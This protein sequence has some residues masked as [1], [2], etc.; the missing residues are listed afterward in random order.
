MQL[1][2]F[3]GSPRGMGSN[4]KVIIE[5]FLKGFESLENNSHEL[6][7]LIRTQEQEIFK[8]TFQEAEAVLVVF[9][10]YTDSMPGI[11]KTFIETLEPLC[12][13]ENNPPIAF[14][15][16]SGFPEGVHLRSLEKYL[17]KLACRL[18]CRYIGTVVKGNSESLQHSPDEF[19]DSWVKNF[20][21][22]GEIFAKTGK[23]E[24]ELLV[25]MSKPEKFPGW[26]GGFF[27]LFARTPFLTGFWDSEM[28]KKRG[29]QTAFCKTL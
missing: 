16:H 17:E 28:K 26:M 6:F 11:V 14:I 25:K 3:N 20:V 4:S 22:L 21:E 2:V 23:F 12:G 1:T 18:G 15:I 29:L 8:K 19:R 10:L 7:Y 24:K 5:G 27:N 13:V 9:P